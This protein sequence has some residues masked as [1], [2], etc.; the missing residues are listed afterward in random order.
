MMNRFGLWI[1]RYSTGAMFTYHGFRKDAVGIAE[2]SIRGTDVAFVIVQAVIV[3]E[4][5]YKI[6][7]FKDEKEW[8]SGRMNGIGGSDASA[9]VGVNPYKTNIELFEEKT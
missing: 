6:Y 8:L 4:E 9:V 1:I 2:Q 5:I 3:M 7:D